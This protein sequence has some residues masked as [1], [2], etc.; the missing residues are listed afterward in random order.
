M[1]ARANYVV[2]Q[3]GSW[4]LHTS[5]WGAAGMATDLAYG[6]AAAIRCFRANPQVPAEQRT[7]PGG[8]L[9]DVW[10]EG[11]ALVDADRRVLL[12]FSGEA[13]HWVEQAAHRAVLERAWAGWEVRWAFDGI[14]DLHAYL[15]LGRAFV[16]EPGFRETGSSFWEPPE[17]RID[18]LVTVTGQDGVTGAWGSIYDVDEELCGGPGLPGHLPA[19]IPPPEL[20]VMPTGGLH[21]DLPTRTLGIWTV[22][23]VPGIHDW[24]LPGWEDWRLDFWG[25]DHREQ[26]ARS[27]G[28]AR[29]PEVDLRP[30]L[31][32]WRDRIGDPPLDP[33]ALLALAVRAPHGR[34]DTVAVVD[35]RATVK[36]EAPDPTD[37][38]R[39]ALAAVFA[40]LVA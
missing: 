30:E 3:G 10:C 25:A 23:I 40:T 17:G 13:N 34:D 2:M 27:G 7:A 28:G 22:G 24:P 16:R 20:P 6:P 11:A 35:P 38:E 36:H 39:A 1:G 18:T 5:R 32:A 14:G 33:A 26:L 19:G 12:W 9:D 4:T 8:W 37:E 15:G 29:F 21:F 31:A